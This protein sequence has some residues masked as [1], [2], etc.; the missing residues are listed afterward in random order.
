MSYLLDTCAL[1]EMIK[2]VPDAG[3]TEWIASQR[4]DLLFISVISIAEIRQ[5]IVRLTDSHRRRRLSVW[6]SGIKARYGAHV[7]PV[8]LAVSETYGRMQGKAIKSGKPVPVQDCWIAATAATHSLSIVTRDDKDLVPTGVSI[9][10][11]WKATR[12]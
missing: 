8:D 3:F 7:L 11:P 2:K 5:G 6:L 1:S 9:V 10:N 4:G 12:G